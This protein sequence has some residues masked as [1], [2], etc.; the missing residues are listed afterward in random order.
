M[1]PYIELCRDNLGDKTER[2]RYSRNVRIE[3]G[4]RISRLTTEFAVIR[5]E[6][7]HEGDKTYVN[8]PG[9]DIDNVTRSRSTTKYYTQRNA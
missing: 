2:F 6:A 7:N 4:I 5:F 3:S 8:I 1:F 9:Y